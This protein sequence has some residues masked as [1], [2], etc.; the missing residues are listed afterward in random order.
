ME[1]FDKQPSEY[2]TE[3]LCN[4]SVKV[5]IEAAISF[6]W[7]KYI[8]PHGIFIGMQNFGASAPAPKLFD[9]F[10]INTDNVVQQVIKKIKS[11]S[12]RKHGK[13]SN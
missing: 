13:S 7:D 10:G 11:R 1:L 6:G 5:A 3:I 8:G 2:I 12:I 4:N 9:Y